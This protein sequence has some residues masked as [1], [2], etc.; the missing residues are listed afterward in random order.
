MPDRRA[1]RVSVLLAAAVLAVSAC[2]GSA[3]GGPAGG[4]DRP[5]SS[6]LASPA[7]PGR[8][9]PGADWPVY[10]RDAARTGA[11][12]GRPAAGPLRLAWTRRLD[13]AVYGQPLVIGGLVV[14]A[15]END[16]VYALDRG[17][18]R[19]RWRR[20]V[21]TPVPLSSLPCGNI[22]PLGITGTPAYDPVTRL[23]Y[24]V[25]EETG[26]RHVLY[27]LTLGGVIR[28]RR[29]LP[30]PDGHPRY[31]QQRPALA[32]VGGRVY[33]SFGGLEGDCGPYIGSVTG[34]PASGRGP[35][36]AYRVPT[37]REG[38]IWEIGRA[39]CRERV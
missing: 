5:A 15:T 9:A 38:A 21:G 34:V 24:A 13:G 12:P 19:I 18:G 20:H 25:A 29:D 8:P 28:V 1:P 26:F 11:A 17:T 35:L 7:N 22:D 6:G 36:L 2:S 32:V 27:G 39:S 10:H 16:S 14:A 23:V 4:G 31:D 33:V 37:R 3:P 30:A